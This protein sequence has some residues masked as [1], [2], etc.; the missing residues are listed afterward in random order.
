[1]IRFDITGHSPINSGRISTQKLWIL[2]MIKHRHSKTYKIQSVRG[3]IYY[4]GHANWDAVGLWSRDLL[5]Y[6]ALTAQLSPSLTELSEWVLIHYWEELW[7]VELC[8]GWLLESSTES[9][10]CF[11]FL[12]RPFLFFL[13]L[14][15][16]VIFLNA[17]NLRS[18]KKVTF[19][20]YYPQTKH[21]L[22]CST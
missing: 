22:F 2:L 20:G 7:T 16:F 15:P 13:L 8:S 21:S 3:H 11:W 6:P 17:I 12:K 5:S 19:V 10:W 9:F 18:C 14:T 1:M 4:T